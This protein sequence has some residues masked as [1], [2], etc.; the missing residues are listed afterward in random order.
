MKRS[1]STALLYPTVT[2]S[3]IYKTFFMRVTPDI[4]GV[5]SFYRIFL[6]GCIQEKEFYAIIFSNKAP[7]KRAARKETG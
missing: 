5:D 3:Q 6:R 2:S 4:S 1:N 7:C